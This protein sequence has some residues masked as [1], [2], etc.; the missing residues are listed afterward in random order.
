MRQPTQRLRFGG[1]LADIV[2]FTKFTYLLNTRVFVEVYFLYRMNQ[3]TTNQ[4][5]E[6]TAIPPGRGNNNYSSDSQAA[7]SPC[8]RDFR[9]ANK[10][11]V[12]FDTRYRI[13]DDRDI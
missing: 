4:Q 2:R 3:P 8:D 1:P 7:L 13:D 5:T 12:Q 11:Y 6:R 9:S 10:S